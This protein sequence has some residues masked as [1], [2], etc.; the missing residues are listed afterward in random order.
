MNAILGMTEL[1]LA[2]GPPEPVREQLETVRASGQV[3]LELLNDI[4]D[5]SRIESGHLSIE[6]APF[7]VRKLV[8]EEL[9]DNGAD[10]VSAA[11]SA[12]FDVVLMDLQMPRMDGFDATQ[13]IRAHEPPVGVRIIALTAHAMAGDREKALAAGMDDYLSKPVSLAALERALSE[14]SEPRPSPS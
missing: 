13:R 1:A 7:S 9:V 5:L 6:E 2:K 10:A 14:P 3:L 11:T 12:P 4:L 8:D